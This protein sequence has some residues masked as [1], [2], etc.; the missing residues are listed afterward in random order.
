MSTSAKTFCF[1]MK[2]CMISYRNR[3]QRMAIISFWS[4]LH[5]VKSNLF[6]YYTN[7]K[8]QQLA[9]FYRYFKIIFVTYNLQQKSIFTNINFY[10]TVYGINSGIL[11]SMCKDTQMTL[12]YVITPMFTFIF[13]SIFFQIFPFIFP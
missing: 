12:K 1:L 3:T 13:R 2:H 7:K 4:N 11:E 9:E 6:V 10:K 8:K 5:R